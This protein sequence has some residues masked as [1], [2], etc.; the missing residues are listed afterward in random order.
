MAN[1]KENPNQDT[2]TKT[3]LEII[4]VIILQSQIKAV[5]AHLISAILNKIEKMTGKK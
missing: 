4:Q 5:D 3:D 2:L 1:K